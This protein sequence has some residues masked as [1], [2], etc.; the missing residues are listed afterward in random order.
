MDLFEI[1]L[2]FLWSSTHVIKARCRLDDSTCCTAFHLFYLEEVIL[3]ADRLRPIVQEFLQVSERYYYN[4]QIV[5]GS[6]YRCLFD[7]GISHG[8]TDLV[9]GFWT[10]CRLLD[11]I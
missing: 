7:Y 5:Q 11:F 6:L 8:T 10:L 1:I 9:N 4:R 2:I 3:G